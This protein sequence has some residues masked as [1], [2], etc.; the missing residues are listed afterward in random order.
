MHGREEDASKQGQAERAQS[1]PSPANI[2]SCAVKQGV[3]GQGTSEAASATRGGPERAARLAWHYQWL[4]VASLLL[5][6]G[7]CC[8]GSGGLEP[9][10]RATLARGSAA[11]R[12]CQ[13]SA[14]L[15]PAMLT[16]L[17]PR[18]GAERGWTRGKRDGGR[19][20]T[21]ELMG[22]GESQAGIVPK[23]LR[24]G[25]DNVDHQNW[26]GTGH[27]AKIKRYYNL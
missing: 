6:G 24:G 26:R 11:A 19:G 5:P 15:R 10:P 9:W 12:R 8:C 17:Q 25:N 7:L 18:L 13:P 22:G 16:A 1:H 3:L 20:E 4:V 14:P 27:K 23:A 21:G 2:W